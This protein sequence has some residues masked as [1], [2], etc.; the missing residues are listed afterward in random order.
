MKNVYVKITIEDITVDLTERLI[1]D[2]MKKEAIEN[3]EIVI[4]DWTVNLI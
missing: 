2:L 4:T 1:I 3:Y